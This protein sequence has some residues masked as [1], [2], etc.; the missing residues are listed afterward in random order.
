MNVSIF[1]VLSAVVRRAGGT[2]R[3][4]DDWL[5]KHFA[6]RLADTSLGGSVEH[7]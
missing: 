2:S 1:E 5:P 6:G 4:L 7:I 3:E